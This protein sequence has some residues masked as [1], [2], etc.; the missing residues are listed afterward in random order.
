MPK[1]N[2]TQQEYVQSMAIASKGYD[3]YGILAALMRG[4]DS[5]NLAALR[6]RF[7]G[8]WES[9]LDW[10]EQPIWPLDQSHE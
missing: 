9:L 6:A 4:A 7:P 1:T 10:R 5:E 2:L 8:I 3:F